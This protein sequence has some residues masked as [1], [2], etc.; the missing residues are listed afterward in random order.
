VLREKNRIKSLI[1]ISNENL[2]NELYSLL[3]LIERE[4]NILSRKETIIRVFSF[5]IID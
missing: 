3:I 5:V 1:P 4:V 2:I